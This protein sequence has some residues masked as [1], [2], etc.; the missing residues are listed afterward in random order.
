VV[1]IS[2]TQVV[3]VMFAAVFITILSGYPLFICIGAV[4]LIVGYLALGD[5]VFGLLRDRTIALLTNHILLAVPLFVFMGTI[6][7]RSG[8]A[9]RLYGGLYIWFGGF[10]GGLAIVTVL[11][12]TILA[13]CVGVIIASVSMIGLVALPGMMKRGYN[14]ELACGSACAGGTLG[15]LIPPSIMLVIYGPMAQISVGQLFMAAIVPGLMLSSLYVSYIAISCWFK[16]NWAPPVPIEE[17]SQPLLKKVTLLITGIL[18]PLFII[19]SVLGTIFLGIASPTEAAAVGCFA[20]IILAAIYRQLNFQILKEVT[21]QTMQ[22]SCMALMIGASAFMF[23]G[24]FLRLG[25]DEAIRNL[26][27]TAPLSKWGIF[28]LIMFMLFVL[29]MFID[30]L[31]IL[32]VMVPLITPIGETLGFHPLWFAMMICIN[33]QMS[34]LT[35]PF[36]YAIFFLRGLTKPEWGIE[37]SH[38]MKGVI[39]F[40]LMIMIGLGLCIAFPEL[41]LWLPG[42]MIK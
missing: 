36:A 26:I 14:K 19:F 32:F 6:V 27:V 8:A 15:I 17:R 39:P 40:V 7:A 4:A 33:L 18:P 42:I 28:A 20:G 29:G 13:A 2:S 16:P 25:G 34:F 24:V 35:P 30:W 12:G 21:L 41:I 1:D 10:R 37:T 5:P 38:I 22:V 31:G 11:M 3:I 23:T 9:E